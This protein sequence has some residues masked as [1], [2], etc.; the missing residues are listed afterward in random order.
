MA[1]R[2]ND[3]KKTIK[4]SKKEELVEIAVNFGIISSKSEANKITI[5]QL[6]EK[7]GIDTDTKV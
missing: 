2:P 6:Q 7:I 4:L 3:Q 1:E 5:K